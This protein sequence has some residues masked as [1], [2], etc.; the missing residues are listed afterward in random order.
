MKG[1]IGMVPVRGGCAVERV[2]VTGY[3]SARPAGGQR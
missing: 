3:T 2:R 1:G